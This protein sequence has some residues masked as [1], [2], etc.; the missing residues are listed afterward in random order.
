M[1][2]LSLTALMVVIVSA[3]MGAPGYVAAAGCDPASGCC[4]TGQTYVGQQLFPNQAIPAQVSVSPVARPPQ[5]IR[6][7][8]VA[9]GVR[10]A[11]AVQVKAQLVVPMTQQRVDRS[12]EA[13]I[14]SYMP[15]LG[16]LW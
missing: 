3:T 12:P 1:N 10:N 16:T 14:F 5:N 7:T 11:R 4:G 8:N 13:L 9:G 6:A 2:K 15:C